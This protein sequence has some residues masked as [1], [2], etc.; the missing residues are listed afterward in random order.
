MNKR[1]ELF[2]SVKMN[3]ETLDFKSVSNQ[4]YW[5]SPL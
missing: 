5:F 3:T 4:Y 1:F 2:F